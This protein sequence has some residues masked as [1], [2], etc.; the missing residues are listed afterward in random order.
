M[1]GVIGIFLSDDFLS[2][3]KNSKIDWEEI[4]HIIISFINEYYAEGRDYIVN[5]DQ[6]NNSENSAYFFFLMSVWHVIHT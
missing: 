5:D 2:V 1:N 4:K 6:E 3:N